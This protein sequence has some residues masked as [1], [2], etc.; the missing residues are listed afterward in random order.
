MQKGSLPAVLVFLRALARQ[1]QTNQGVLN[2]AALTYT[3]LFAVVPLMTVSYSMLAAVPNFRGVGEQVQG[4]IFENFVP[5]TGM[6]VQEYLST[7]ASQAQKLTVIG[8][9]FLVITS[10]MMMKNI[11]AAFNRIWRVTEPRK[12][13][14]SFLLYW[15]VLSL[16]P[17]L[18]GLGLLLTS[19]IASLPFISSATEVVGRARLLS[20][21]PP[22]FSALA[23]MLLY[24]AVPNCR[25]PLR[26][27][28]IGGVFA[29][30]LFELAK[31]G[32]AL[33]V[34]QFPSY[35]LIYGAFAAVPMF[36]VWIFISWTIILLGAELTRLLTVSHVSKYR[37]H[38]PHLYTVLAVLQRLWVAQ[39]EG[40][41][42]PDRVLLQEIPGLDQGRWDD[43]V[44]LLMDAGL[45]RR[46]EGG[47]YLL[48]RDLSRY[49]LLQLQRE[50][51]WPLPD[52][53][54]D[55]EE[56]WQQEL[57]SRLQMLQ[58]QRGVVL[59]ITLQDLYRRGHIPTLEQ[60]Q[61]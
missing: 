27:A 24:A 31:R 51:P 37:T 61:D 17:I 12:G 7:F 28:A 5:A 2:A 40:E 56:P 35:E 55:R 48:S 52:P 8:I 14:S 15:A 1:Y 38:E 47:Q 20:L 33:F 54:P 53:L 60:I 4:W 30:V 9:V 46:T 42:V 59:N 49:T 50:M 6:V 44:Q 26:N 13:L 34:T 11:E 22:L 29:A 18:I 23:F 43:Y 39:Q 21:L 10:I 19:Y 45:I 36:L 57:H 58:R 25:V 3:T 41:P 16:G 32:F